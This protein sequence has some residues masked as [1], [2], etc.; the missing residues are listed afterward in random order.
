MGYRFNNFYSEDM[1]PFIG[2][3]TRVLASNS[4]RG[5]TPKFIRSMRWAENA[6]QA[7]DIKLMRDT[8]YGIIESRRD[9]P[10]DK[11]DLLTAMLDG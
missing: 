2:A 1:H 5:R 4:K 8:S 10:T 7:V 3:M 6:Q 11:Q 9:H